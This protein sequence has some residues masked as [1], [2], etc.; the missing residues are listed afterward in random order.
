[1]MKPKTKPKLEVVEQFIDMNASMKRGNV[2]LLTRLAQ[3]SKSNID[4]KE[5]KSRSKNMYNKL[6]EQKMKQ[7]ERKKQQDII[8]RQKKMQ[9]YAQNLRIKN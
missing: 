2:E 8:E 1:M 5:S 3:G 7:D 9:E 6:P 4:P